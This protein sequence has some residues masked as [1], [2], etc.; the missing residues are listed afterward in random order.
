MV[1]TS[2][3]DRDDTPTLVNNSSQ[4]KDSHCIEV[5]NKH[6]NEYASSTWVIRP[7]QDF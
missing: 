6:I 2:Q 3:I 1:S 7:H 4:K 5:V